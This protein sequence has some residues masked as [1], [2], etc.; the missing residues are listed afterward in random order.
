M[1]WVPPQ[2]STSEKGKKIGNLDILDLLPGIYI[3]PPYIH[4][5]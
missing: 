1:K 4:C 3:M 5:I 2:R